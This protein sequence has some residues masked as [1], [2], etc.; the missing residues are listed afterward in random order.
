M[1]DPVFLIC[2]VCVVQHFSRDGK[3][4]SVTRA[5]RGGYF[6]SALCYIPVFSFGAFRC[7]FQLLFLPLPFSIVTLYLV[8]FAFDF[9]TI[10]SAYN[11][12][13]SPSYSPSLSSQLSYFNNISRSI[14]V[15]PCFLLISALFS[16]VFRLR[17]SGMNR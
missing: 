12:F 17:E 2:W 3:S 16:S 5:S 11:L 1:F 14:P 6:H 15:F 10:Y 8:L 7:S 13:S 4:H 9:L